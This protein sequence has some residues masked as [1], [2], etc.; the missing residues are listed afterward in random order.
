MLHLLIHDCSSLY[1]Y[2]LDV[3]YSSF[4]FSLYSII[5]IIFSLAVDLF[6][7]QDIFSY[8]FHIPS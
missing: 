7:H 6:F 3:I 5:K 4:L 1:T 8:V 2:F